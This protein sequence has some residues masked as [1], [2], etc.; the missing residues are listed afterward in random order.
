MWPNVSFHV[1]HKQLHWSQKARK[2]VWDFSFFVPHYCQKIC[3][4]CK[5]YCKSNLKPFCD[6]FLTPCDGLLKKM[7]LENVEAKPWVWINRWHSKSMCFY[8]NL[9][10]FYS[11]QFITVNWLRHFCDPYKNGKT[12]ACVSF[13]TGFNIYCSYIHLTETYLP[14]LL[15]WHRLISIWCHRL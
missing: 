1:V 8:Q 15:I 6:A 2:L 13:I 7:M 5:L 3:G 11:Q 12:S 14:I 9:K 4:F 10:V